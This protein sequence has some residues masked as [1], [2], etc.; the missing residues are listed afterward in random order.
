MWITITEQHY[1][2]HNEYKNGLANSTVECN[3]AKT[4]LMGGAAFLSLDASFIWLATLMLLNNA[5]QDYLEDF[6]QPTNL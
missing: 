1:L 4:G 6:I 2:E 5:R 3:T